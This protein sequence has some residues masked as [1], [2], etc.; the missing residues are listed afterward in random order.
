MLLIDCIKETAELKDPI[1]LSLLIIEA[2]ADGKRLNNPGQI[3]GPHW[4]TGNSIYFAPGL[5]LST[6][7]AYD[8]GANGGAYFSTEDF[9]II[10]TSTR[11][12]NC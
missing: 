2:V 4:T 9:L 11:R 6:N 5:I 12:K 7:V 1:E 3:G 10:N 8:D